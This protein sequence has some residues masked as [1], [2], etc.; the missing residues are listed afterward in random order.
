MYLAQ[1]NIAKAKYPL[2]APEIQPFVENLEPVN[3][4]AEQSEGFVWR[5]QET[6]G[7]T[8]NIPLFN[9]SNVIVNMSVWTSP[10]TLKQ[11]MMGDQ[12]KPFLSRKKEWFEP[13][14]AASYVLWWIPKDH[15]PSLEEAA[16]KLHYLRAHGETEQ[17]FTFKH[18]FAAKE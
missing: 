7:E 16:Q 15:I 2:D 5:W 17:A 14:K 18:L 12:H 6:E 4:N 1:L 11:F 13:I 10:D 8:A 9:E 3:L